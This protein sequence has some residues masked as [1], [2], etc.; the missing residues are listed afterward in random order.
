MVMAMVSAPM[1][2]SPVCP[3]IVKEV[4]AFAE[5]LGVALTVL[6]EPSMFTVADAEAV[7]START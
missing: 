5:L 4:I 7:L 6:G 3:G 2:V 1:T